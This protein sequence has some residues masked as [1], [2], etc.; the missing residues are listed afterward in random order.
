MAVPTKGVGGAPRDGEGNGTAYAATSLERALSILESFTEDRPALTLSQVVGATGL[1]KTTAFRLLTVLT[2]RGFVSRRPGSGEYMAGIRALALAGAFR[3][4]SVLLDAARPVL[5]AIRD[6]LNETVIL[7]VRHGNHRIDV[8]YCRCAH[9]LQAVV[10]LGVAKPL[11]VGAGGRALMTTLSPAELESY[12]AEVPL[13]PLSPT[14]LA[15]R[16]EVEE[17]LAVIRRD[18]I[19]ESLGEANTGLAGFAIPLACPP[20]EPAAALV[21][22]IPLQRQTPALRQDVIAAFREGAEAIRLRLA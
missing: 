20:G 16:R 6:R 14:T 1:N 4:R 5:A 22:S 21:A 9:A 8:E 3:A 7:S 2:R 11:Y 18:G 19:A 15:T 13:R 10:T 17:A 12:F